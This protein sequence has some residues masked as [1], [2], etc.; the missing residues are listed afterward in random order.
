M[1]EMIVWFF[2]IVGNVNLLI[3]DVIF[4]DYVYDEE[5]MGLL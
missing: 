5:L 1:S 2:E 4:E 3:G